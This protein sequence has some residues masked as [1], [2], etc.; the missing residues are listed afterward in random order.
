MKFLDSY[1]AEIKSAMVQQRATIYEQIFYACGDED[2]A[3]R[4]LEIRTGGFDCGFQSGAEWMLR[5]ILKELDSEQ[6]DKK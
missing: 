3:H 6:E 1:E 4:L 2:E 5:R